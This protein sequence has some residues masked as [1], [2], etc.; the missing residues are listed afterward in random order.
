MSIEAKL[1]LG[2]MTRESAIL[3]LTHERVPP[4]T[5]QEAETLWTQYHGRVEAL[6]PEPNALPQ[7]LNDVDKET[8]LRFLRHCRENGKHEI[9]DVIK[10]D[11]ANLPI[12][13]YR[14]VV[15]KSRDYEQLVNT[16]HGWVSRALPT[17]VQ[18]PN[19]Q[20]RYS[21]NGSDTEAWFDLPHSEFV[22]PYSPTINAFQIKQF[23]RWV[24]AVR[25]EQRYLLWSGYHRSLARLVNTIGD[26]N[27]R[28]ALIALTRSRLLDTPN[29]S[30]DDTHSRALCLRAR[31]AFLKDFLND[32][33]CITLNLKKQKWLYHVKGEV[34]AIEDLT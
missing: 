12:R 2:W 6:P 17:T 23:D 32:E 15:P 14:I 20:A 24:V 16:R 1:L 5:E 10:L 11:L 19:L 4:L 3:W 27:E 25:V 13:Q 33:L 8:R 21:Q 30:A 28:S 9:E 18:E 26:G 22:F 34:V 29:Q 31:P 7:K